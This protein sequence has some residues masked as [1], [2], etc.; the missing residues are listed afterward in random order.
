MFF[1][2]GVNELTPP[3]SSTVTL[4]FFYARDLYRKRLPAPGPCL[5][6]NV[7]EVFYLPWPDTGGV[8]KQQQ[9][10]E[11][12]RHDA[13]QRHRCARVPAP[14]QRVAPHVCELGRHAFEERWLDEGM[15]HIAEELNFF[16][17]RVVRL[18]SNLDASIFRPAG[19]RG[20]LH[21]QP[22]QFPS[23]RAVHAAH[24]DAGPVG[25]DAFDDDLPTR[26]A[27]WNFLRFA[28]DT[29]ADE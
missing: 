27:V 1:T 20:V 4:G 25:F 2:Q 14:D 6:S 11:S 13:D 28:A 19:Q 7:G 21:V 23:V 10:I 24:R 18:A 17:R 5:G 8:V 26:G 3:Q 15:A 22:E 9:A 12:A 16:G 29:R